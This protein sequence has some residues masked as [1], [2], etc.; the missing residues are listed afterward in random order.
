MNEGI[1]RRNFIGGAA[2]GGA[3]LALGAL[4][5]CAPQGD[6]PT[7][8]EGAWDAEV[9]LLVCGCGGAGMACA[10]EAKDNGV[11]NVLIIE[12]GDQIGGTTAM[13]Q[14]MIAGRASSSPTTRCMRT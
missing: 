6:K 5:G 1:S 13:S 9:D 7:G 14:G 10:V 2:L 4:A 11:E 3:A 8:S 12:K